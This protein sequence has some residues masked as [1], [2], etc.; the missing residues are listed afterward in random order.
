[1]A[2]RI[3][4]RCTIRVQNNFASCE[5]VR[6]VPYDLLKIETRLYLFLC[7]P[8]RNTIKRVYVERETTHSSPDA[9]VFSLS[10]VH[11]NN[12]L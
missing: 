10:L 6:A 3:I 2:I 5:I 7:K 8:V 1:M 9:V 4:C 12:Q 11:F